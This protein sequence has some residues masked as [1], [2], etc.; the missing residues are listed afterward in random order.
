MK[1]NVREFIRVLHELNFILT[2]KQKVEFIVV[3]FVLLISAGL[4]LIGV[5]AV[6]PFI[7]AVIN[8]DLLLEK[9]LVSKIMQMVGWTSPKE[10]LLLIG[11]GVILIYLIKNAYMVFACYFQSVYSSH[12]QEDLSNRVMQSYLKRPYE[13]FLDENS[14]NVIQVCGSDVS[15][16]YSIIENILQ[17]LTECLNIVFIASFL[18]YSDPII[19]MGILFVM[20]VVLIIIIA[21]FKPIMKRVGKKSREVAVKKYKLVIQVVNGIKEL[22]VLQRK[23]YVLNEY[24]KLTQKARKYAKLEGTIKGCPDRIVEGA[25]VTGILGVICFRLMISESNAVEFVPTLGVF[26]MAAFKVFPSVGK[27]ASRIS[28]IVYVRPCLGAVYQKLFE[29]KEDN[30]K[31]GLIRKKSIYG[32]KNFH[33]EKE[34]DVSHVMWQYKEQNNAVLSDINFTINKGEAIGLIGASGAGKTTLADIILGLLCPRKGTVFADGIDVL[35]ISERWAQIIGY[36]PQAVYLVDDNIRRNVAFCIPDDEIDDERVWSALRD[37]QLEEFVRQLP[38]KLD[39]IVGERGI[40]FSGG[41]RQRVAIARALYNAP[42]ILVLDEATSALDVGT[43]QA[44]MESIEFLKNKVTLIIV[45]HRLE[46]IKSCDKI[47]EIVDGIAVER[48]MEEIFSM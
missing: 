45:A 29:T 1:K 43:E 36:V 14:S 16:M 18:L 30:V 13:Y 15:S 44:V 17:I 22:S 32:E 8:P 48:K 23:D 21:C 11:G 4:E 35:S 33:F 25:C 9:P 19:A 31:E 46:T 40:K 12:V 27:I 7:Q 39:T 41:Q 42:E 28:T 24:K 5:T 2:K 10:L 20:G 3:Y 47:Y 38:E 37:A 26:A 6:L 34:L